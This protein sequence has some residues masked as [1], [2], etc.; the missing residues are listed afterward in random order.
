MHIEEQVWHSPHLGREMALKVYG[1]W[2]TPF[3]VFPCSRGRYCSGPVKTD[4]VL[5]SI[6]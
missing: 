1:H 2:G 3:I 6:V 5:S 4:T